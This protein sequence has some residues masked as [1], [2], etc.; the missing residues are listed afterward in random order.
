MSG[1]ILVVRERGSSSGFGL[2]SPGGRVSLWKAEMTRWRLGQG[3]RDGKYGFGHV[4]VESDTRSSTQ[5][6]V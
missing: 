3:G 1:G 4:K 6:T 5:W 2:E